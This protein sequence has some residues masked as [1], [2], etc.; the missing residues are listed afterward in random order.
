MLALSPRASSVLAH[1]VDV[2]DVQQFQS[3]ERAVDRAFWRHHQQAILAPRS[4][5]HKKQSIAQ[6]HLA[7]LGQDR[8]RTLAALRH[9]IT[10]IDSAL[11][12]IRAVLRAVVFVLQNNH[13]TCALSTD[14]APEFCVSPS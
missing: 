6:I 2:F 1:V 5:G 13:R 12:L 3:R 7:E 11:L 10:P 14:V 9:Q 4:K 8:G